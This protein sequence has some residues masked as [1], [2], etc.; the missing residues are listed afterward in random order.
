MKDLT[1]TIKINRAAQDV[2]AFVIDPKNTHTWIDGITIEETN[3]WPVKLGA[4]YRNRGTDGQW[5]EFTLTEFKPDRVFA[6]STTEGFHVR[7]TCKPLDA[8][9]SELEFYEWIDDGEL[10]KVLTDETLEKLKK[11]IEEQHVHED[12]SELSHRL[13][14]AGHQ[15]AVGARYMHYKQLSYKV[16]G[17]ALREED[18]EPCVIY[19]AEYGDS[20]TWLR[21]VS[22]WIQEIE[23]DSKKV[24]RFV[25]ID[26]VA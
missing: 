14:E 26:S 2:F 21:P 6:L 19:Q 3:E 4:I 24:R 16:I 18:N 11:I 15:V 12:Q 17:L 1:L 25:R 13:A 7:Y 9:T 20:V 5:R 23:V 10:D 22:N 8:S